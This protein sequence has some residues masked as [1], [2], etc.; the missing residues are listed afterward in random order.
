MF[1]SAILVILGT[2]ITAFVSFFVVVSYG[3][4]PRG[5]YTTH[6]VSVLWARML[7]WITSVEVEVVGQGNVLR[8]RPHEPAGCRRQLLIR[9]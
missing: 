3:L 4:F 5:E 9:T 2:S 7:L 8:G 6:R 1:R